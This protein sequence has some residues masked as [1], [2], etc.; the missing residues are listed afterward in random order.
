MADIHDFPI[1]KRNPQVG[2]HFAALL[3]NIARPALVPMV[4]PLFHASVIRNALEAAIPTADGMVVE[5]GKIETV[6]DC[7][8]AL[9][10]KDHAGQTY[11][12][13]VQVERP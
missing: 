13:T 3:E 1:V 11:R 4:Y 5:V 8:Y 10:T 6:A 9:T 7:R 12:I 2:D